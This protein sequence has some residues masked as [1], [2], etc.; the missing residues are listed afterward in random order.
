MIT[1]LTSSGQCN[2][3]SSSLCNFVHS[4]RSKWPR[5][6]RRGS[7]AA[8]LLGLLFRIPPGALLF[9]SSECCVLLCRGPW[10]RLI[11]R[12]EESYRVWCVWVWSWSL[13]NEE[14]PDPVGTVAPCEK[15]SLTSSVLGPHV[16]SV[17]CPWTPSA[18]VL[19]LCERPSLKPVTT[20]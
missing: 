8:R 20:E 9:V 3:C 15:I 16:F 2:S 5:G 13:D 18:Y 7:A 19:S 17:H 1:T 11:T 6:Q 14:G 4:G 12:P 10:I